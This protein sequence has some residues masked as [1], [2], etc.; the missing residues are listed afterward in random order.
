MRILFLFISFLS[1]FS[2]FSQEKRF[3]EIYQECIYDSLPNKGERLKTYINDFEKHL[4]SLKIL[5][6]SDGKSYLDLFKTL[7]EG[8]T[9]P[10][11]YSYS[12][13]D[14]INNLEINILPRNIRC[15]EKSVK[16][17]SYADFFLR[18]F[19]KDEY[20]KTKNLSKV[21]NPEK[22]FK[23]VLYNTYSKMKPEDYELDYY[24]HNLFMILYT[25]N[26]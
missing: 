4:I 9:Y 22:L 23:E 10:S 14:S 11:K 19:D 3:E 17:K 16:D 18:F 13:L 15:Y 2:V 5:K 6:N 7:I 25:V 26:W 20:E 1:L 24:K 12:Y 21:K 8:K